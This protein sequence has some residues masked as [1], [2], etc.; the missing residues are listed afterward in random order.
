MPTVDDQRIEQETQRIGRELFR[1][2]HQHGARLSEQ[3]LWARQVMRWCLGEP[4]VRAQV[5]RFVD[6]LPSL[7]SSRAIVEHLRAAFPSSEFHLPA[8][9]RVGVALA[10]PSLVTATA[11]AAAVRFLVSQVARQFI[12]GETEAEVVTSLAR[13][14]SQGMGYTLDLLGEATTS[15]AEADAY[16]D[17]YLAAL[18][19]L[20]R[21]A[22]SINLSIKLSALS[23]R[24]DPMAF[25]ASVEELVNRLR[26]VMERARDVG[27]CI[28]LDM[29]QY[30]TRDLTLEV[31]K[32]LLVAPWLE[33]YRDLGVVIQAYLVDAE[34]VTRALLDWLA[35]H[36][37]TLTIRLVRGAYWDTERMIAGAYGWPSPVWV[38]KM[39]TDVVFERISRRL[40]ERHDQV[41]TAIASHNVRSVAHAMTLVDALGVPRERIE[42]Q[43]LYG[44]AD[45][46]KQAVADAGWPVRVYT[47]YGVLIP[48]MA[49]LVRRIVENTSNESFLRLDL[50]PSF[51]EDEA[52]RPPRRG[53]GTGDKG[54]GTESR[55][56]EAGGRAQ[57]I[58]ESEPCSRVSSSRSRVSGFAQRATSDQRPTTEFRNEPPVDWS[59]EEARHQIGQALERV[60]QVLGR[61]YPLRIDGA[62]VVSGALRASV[63]PARRHEV[64]G[65]VASAGPREVDLA[66]AA[67]LRAQAA[68]AGTPVEERARCL[69]RA[70]DSLVKERFDF[71]AWEVVEV[72]K[73]WREADADVTEAVD[74]LRYYADQMRRLATG[75]PMLEPP[76]ERN[77]YRYRPRGV[78]VVIAPWNFPLALLA[79]MASAALVAGNTVIAKP[80]GQAAVLASLWVRLMHRAGVPVGAL[81]YLPGSGEEIG[82]A[83]VRHPAVAAV[84]FTGSRDVGLAIQ[85]AA[86]HT[87]RGQQHVK[88]VIAEMGGKNAIIVDDDADL[89]EAVKA[90]MASAFGYAGQKCS[91]CSRLIVLRDV[92]EP[93]L[94]RLAEAMRSLVVSDPEDPRCVIGPLIDEAAQRRVTRY[95]EEGQC[96]G[97]LLYR[98]E[99]GEL[100][101]RGFYV[102]PALFA[103]VEPGSPLAQ[104][105]I[106][107]PVLAVMPAERF[108][109]ALRLANSTPY[110]LT[111]G[112]FSR[113]P[114]HIAQAKEAFAVGNLYINRKITGAVVGRQPFGGFRLSGI[115]SKTGGPDY[116][117]QCLLPQTITESSVRHGMPLGAADSAPHEIPDASSQ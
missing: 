112:L 116:L 67:C 117:Q 24:L 3:N 102:G 98:A 9:L 71:I 107:G 20:A 55:K 109:E 91:A 48:G 104:E 106:F 78:T 62:E 54:Q 84:A 4:R 85:E 7:R 113:H 103:D 63:N 92:Y 15:D 83:L 56:Q 110:A 65:Q 72:G 28:T 79:G 43:M 8:S 39:Q 87:P 36:Q 105:E 77:I 29:E 23:P 46:L 70:A 95:I 47:P 76:G 108:E 38:E 31:A 37:R 82:M 30:A 50:D 73:N 75:Q 86:A 94:A 60:R 51:S 21:A 100:A 27:A 11:A 90:V 61:S 16:R 81:Q 1:L 2:V 57:E 13:L 69:E 18:E 111:G 40:L 34:P 58:G 88:R 97:R 80:A 6:V 33:G 89:D 44:M 14:A 41:R 25:E 93:L 10:R 101:Q 26:P 35:E 17:R 114:G 74:F 59:H 22:P 96:H 53:Q 32:R 115:G 12:A 49:Y 66:I 42:F 99:V 68:W 19:L 5:L 45:A 52:L 64:V